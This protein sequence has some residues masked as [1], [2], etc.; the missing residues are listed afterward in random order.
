MNLCRC[1]L[2]L[3]LTVSMLGVAGCAHSHPPGI[4]KKEWESMSPRQQAGH[5]QLQAIKERRH[6]SEADWQRLANEAAQRR[7]EEQNARVGT[8]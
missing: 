6:R 1:A 8:Q 3:A 2:A 7:L 5:L 4:S